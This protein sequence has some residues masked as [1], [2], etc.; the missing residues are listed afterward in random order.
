MPERLRRGPASVALASFSEVIG[1]ERLRALRAGDAPALVGFG[2]LEVVRNRLV[3]ELFELG[4]VKL[5]RLNLKVSK[6]G[7]EVK[8]AAPFEQA[9]RAVDEPGVVALN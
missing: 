4:A 5:A 2:V 8:R 1:R 9:Q 3:G 6:V 7:R